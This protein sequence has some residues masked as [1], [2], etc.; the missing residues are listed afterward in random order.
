M[1]SWLQF[2]ITPV[3]I[4]IPAMFRRVV[5]LSLSL[6]FWRSDVIDARR[7]VF[8]IAKTQR[9]ALSSRKMIEQLWHL[10]KVFI[11]KSLTAEK[12]FF[13]PAVAAR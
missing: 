5:P 1:W 11:L 12:W 2:S 7:C 9:S 13:A 10:K 3:F 8:E 6:Y 4:L